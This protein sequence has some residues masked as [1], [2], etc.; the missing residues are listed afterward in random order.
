MEGVSRVSRRHPSPIKNST[1]VESENA[2]PSLRTRT[3]RRREETTPR[4]ISRTR[5]RSRSSDVTTSTTETLQLQSERNERFDSKRQNSRTRSRQTIINEENF[6]TTLN[7]DTQS[8]SRSRQVTR[9]VTSQSTTTPAPMPI[10]SP[11]TSRKEFTEPAYNDISKTVTKEVTDLNSQFKRR[12]STERVIE[13]TTTRTRNR[14]NTRTNI[15]TLDLEVSGTANALTTVF[16]EPTTAKTSDLRNSRKLRYKTRQSEVDSNLTGEGLSVPNEVKSSQI[17]ENTT[18]QIGSKSV[19]PSTT[20]TIVKQTT[21]RLSKT[22][23][24]KT[25]KVVKRPIPRGK[26]KAPILTAKPKVSD[27]VHEDDNYPETFKALIQAKNASVSRI[28]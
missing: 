12:S 28:G 16:K 20:E 7:R 5:S 17:G 9:R 14:I 22:S 27:E 13:P 1:T 4:D 25:T 19:S 21:E 23:T 24:I 2:S 8:R 10:S 18:S 3:S 6:D 11:T 15:R 26:V